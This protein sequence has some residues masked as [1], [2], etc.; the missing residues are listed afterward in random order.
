MIVGRLAYSVGHLQNDLTAACWFSYFLLYLQEVVGISH[1]LAGY[2]LLLGQ[3]VDAVATPIIGIKSDSAPLFQCST[4]RKS[5][6]LAGTAIVTV[7]F[8]FLFANILNVI[9]EPTPP[10]ELSTPLYTD[11][12]LYVF[13]DNTTMMTTLSP[14]Q[15][16]G[17]VWQSDNIH[18][19]HAQGVSSLH[20]FLY[21]TPFVVA[22]QIGWAS[23]QV[24]H[25]SL[26]PDIA[27]SYDEKV[28]LNALRYAWTVVANIIVYVTTWIL[29]GVS[30]GQTRNISAQDS[31]V[32]L[33][34]AVTAISIGLLFS[35]VFQVLSPES[36]ERL[37]TYDSVT[38]SNIC[39]SGTPQPD[40][41]GGQRRW[42]EYEY[43]E[44]RH[45]RTNT[46]KTDLLR[47]I[48]PLHDENKLEHGA[49][50]SPQHHRMNWKLWLYEKQFYKIG[51][52]YMFTRLMVNVPQVYLPLYLTHSVQLSKNHIAAIPL[53]VYISGFVYSFCMKWLDKR[54]G[55][56]FLSMIG[57]LSMLLCAIGFSFSNSSRVGVV[58]SAVLMGVGGTASTIAALTMTTDLIGTHKETSAFVYGA[59]SFV[60]KLANGIVIFV[61]QHVYPCRSMKCCA[62]CVDYYRHILVYEPVVCSLL[63]AVVLLTLMK[64]NIGDINSDKVSTV[65]TSEY[66]VPL[67][68]RWDQRGLDTTDVNTPDS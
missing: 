31:L 10:Q 57:C 5:W 41:D 45:C 24:S 18:Q 55:S 9:D 56:K 22:F 63:T 11:K 29:L 8:P 13:G 49:S 2:I 50:D 44:R 30:A 38:D 43:L 28:E 34:L 40:E 4:K 64:E 65:D 20:T 7:S 1:S 16:P 19:K 48:E 53:V 36:K 25:L 59:T 6:H 46:D 68:S 67:E 39:D 62:E 17:D 51:F 23:V 21:Y 12:N 37:D 26:I 32:F 47:E 60:D 66:P 42:D 52:L 61:I 14:D 27:R 35:V 58:G 33:I 3:V 54:V 15:L